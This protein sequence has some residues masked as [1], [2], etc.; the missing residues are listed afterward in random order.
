MPSCGKHG[1][2]LMQHNLH[3][4]YPG[5][6][7]RHCSLSTSFSRAYLSVKT[8]FRPSPINQMKIQR[9]CRLSTIR[10]CHSRGGQG[11]GTSTINFI[12][13]DINTSC[14]APQGPTG[15]ERQVTIRIYQTLY[16]GNT[17][18]GQ[19]S[20]QQHLIGSPIV[21]PFCKRHCLHPPDSGG[22]SFQQPGIN[23]A[24]TE[25][26]VRGLPFKDLSTS[27]G[28]YRGQRRLSSRALFDVHTVAACHLGC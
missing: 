14:T 25:K 1:H 9:A 6:F 19:S 23:Q 16:A 17:P 8:G 26:G 20:I 13:Q 22:G 28:W 15:K 3:T 10:N 21:L 12:F 2:E 4:R 11:S 7:G 27:R 24:P 5:R 18:A